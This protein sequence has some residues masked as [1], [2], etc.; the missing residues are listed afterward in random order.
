MT[1]M[2]KLPDWFHL[3]LNSQHVSKCYALMYEHVAKR[4]SILTANFAWVS[5]QISAQNSEHAHPKTLAVRT[6]TVQR[7]TCKP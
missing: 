6:V 3:R 7:L 2:K 1:T 4:I 5:I